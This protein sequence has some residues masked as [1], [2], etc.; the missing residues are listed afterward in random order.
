M[1]ELR[2]INLRKNY[3]QDMNDGAFWGVTKL[4]TL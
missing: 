2:T 4:N 3:V 1:C